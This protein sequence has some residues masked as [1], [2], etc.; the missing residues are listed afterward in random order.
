MLKATFENEVVDVGQK[1]LGGSGDFL[2]RGGCVRRFGEAPVVPLTFMVG[3]N[4]SSV[5]GSGKVGGRKIVK[6]HTRRKLELAQDDDSKVSGVEMGKR[7]KVEEMFS[8]DSLVTKKVMLSAR[9]P[10][11][12]GAAGLPHHEQ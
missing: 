1:S 5:V 10:E 8:E 3:S 12:V 4:R 2:E 11:V 9:I 6:V 7:K